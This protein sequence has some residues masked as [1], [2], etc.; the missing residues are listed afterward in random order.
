MNLIKKGY[1]LWLQLHVDNQYQ[2]KFVNCET[3]EDAKFLID[4]ASLFKTTKNV[5]KSFGYSEA[6][7]DEILEKYIQVKSK[8]TNLSQSLKTEWQID[9]EEQN[10]YAID[11]IKNHL[12][13]QSW[14][15]IYWASLEKYEVFEVP[16]DLKNVTN[17]LYRN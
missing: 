2:E 8:H 16:S 1:L 3:I 9:D 11:C 15:G 14:N 7:V 6:G 5:R 17:K 4:V 10:E 13:V 12:I